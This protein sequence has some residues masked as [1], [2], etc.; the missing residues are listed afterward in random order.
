MDDPPFSEGG[1]GVMDSTTRF[2][3]RMIWVR[4]PVPSVGPR[5]YDRKLPERVQGKQQDLYKLLLRL[6]AQSPLY[7]LAMSRDRESVDTDQQT[8]APFRESKMTRKPRGTYARDCG[9]VLVKSLTG[10]G[11]CTLRRGRFHRY[12]AGI[13]IPPGRDR[14]SRHRHG[15]L[16]GKRHGLFG[17]Q[18]RGRRWMQGY[19]I[20]PVLCL[21]LF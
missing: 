5:R 15:L 10:S 14:R 2:L 4:I 13:F 1:H 3:N 6:C 9:H 16:G 20:G 11:K 17:E 21:A 7:M 18:R 8:Q 19:V 12:M